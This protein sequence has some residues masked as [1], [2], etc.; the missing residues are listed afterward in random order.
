MKHLV[1]LLALASPPLQVAASQ[2]RVLEITVEGNRLYP[3]EEIRGAMSTK[4]GEVL[5]PK[6][7]QQDVVNLWQYKRVR[8][9]VFQARVPGGI[10][11]VL[12]VFEIPAIR[13]VAVRGNKE[14][15]REDLLDAAKLVP[16]LPIDEVIA[17][18]ARG[19]LIQ[20]YRDRGYF[21]ADVNLQLD[22]EAGRAVF[23]V[24]EGPLVRVGSVEFEGNRTIPSSYF[25][26]L[27][28]S[29]RSVMQISG[30][31]LFIRGS[32]FQEKTLREDLIQLRRLYRMEGYRDAVV[33]VRSLEFTPDREAVTIRILVH[34]GPRYVVSSVDVEGS[35]AFSKEELMALVQLK[36]GD[37]YT[38]DRVERD[39]M[40]LTRYY[41]ERG[42]P[43]HP[44]ISDRWAFET[45]EELY[46]PAEA[47]V[48]VTYRIRE[49]RRIRIRDVQILG[50]EHT[51]DRVIRRALTFF[52]GEFANTTEISRSIARLNSLGY[53]KDE[54]GFP[55]IK[56][57][58]AD[59]ADPSEKDVVLRV[60]EGQ[61][62]EFRFGGGISSVDGFF[63]QI[64][65]QKNNFDLFD[66][67]SSWGRAFRE[68]LDGSAF[69]GA[70]QELS[71]SL[72]P[73]TRIS[74][75]SLRFR[76][77]DL[78]GEHL[79]TTSLETDIFERLRVFQDYEERRSAA[80]IGLG[81][82]WT[83]RWGT[84]L[85]FRN[86]LIELEDIQADAPQLVFDVEGK[87]S[88]QSVRL[89]VAH[90][91][92]DV[93]A[94]PS[95]G[96]H[97]QLSGEWGGGLL[98]GE[99]DFY[100]TVLG[101]RSYVPLGLDL[102][103][104]PYTLLLRGTFGYAESF[105]DSPVVPFPERFFTGGPDSIRGFSFRGVGPKQNGN[106]T[107]GEVL[108]LAGAEFRFPIYSTPF[109][110]GLAES[111]WIRGVLFVDAG[112]L[113]LD[114]H[115]ETFREWRM[116]AGTGVRIRLPFLQQASVVLD[117]GVPIFRQESDN[118]RVFSFSIG[119]SF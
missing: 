32:E 7:L 89:S 37:Y 91:N 23:E 18:R 44:S 15:K 75:Y 19:D 61:T 51:E 71:L 16:G 53:F 82:N 104:R 99:F 39:R 93:P 116:S 101:G 13:D 87:N 78:F 17:A 54:R 30:R 50:N 49:G 14:V 108:G 114:I 34:E 100:K 81:K 36:P 11:L 92:L 112:S 77:P 109:A 21:F 74:T 10:R 43:D 80:D 119:T 27:K 48:R 24:M 115:D 1:L 46:S 90:A 69:T 97:L 6:T 57:S 56:Y 47:R 107:G 84:F 8:T 52:P 86:E 2:D 29:L 118:R 96:Y 98:G 58:F 22:R 62:G 70:G 38:T 95:Q 94:D 68:I 5:N 42:Y 25:L 3:A 40:A 65:L 66:P 67:P 111:E 59:T 106:P 63:A 113:G 103:G 79:R 45:P 60:A 83:D 9:D 85:T 88:L 4:A 110:E 102:R 76:E 28:R 117:Y 105:G 55:S 73:G 26:N 33:E 41:G 35:Q 20:H 64:L 12:R 31:W 72:A